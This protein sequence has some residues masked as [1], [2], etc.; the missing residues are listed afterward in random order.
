MNYF[1]QSSQQ[2]FEVLLSSF[3]PE[4]GGNPDI[5]KVKQVASCQGRRVYD[6]SQ[7]DGIEGAVAVL[8]EHLGRAGD[9]VPRPLLARPCGAG[10]QRLPHAASVLAPRPWKLGHHTGLFSFQFF[11]KASISVFSSHCLPVLCLEAEQVL[12][13]LFE[14]TSWRK[15][16]HSSSKTDLPCRGGPQRPGHRPLTTPSSLLQTVS[17]LE[18]RLTLTE[19]KLKDCLENQQKLCSAVQQKS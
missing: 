12:G 7:M 6:L 15:G 10:P 16:G 17:I 8:K 18:Q 4:N 19:D 2:P 3:G 1:I 9:T 14:P 13:P 11:S 5:L